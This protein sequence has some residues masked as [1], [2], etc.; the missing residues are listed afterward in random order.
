MDNKIIFDTN[1]CTAI[2]EVAFAS[3]PTC[4]AQADI[5]RDFVAASPGAFEQR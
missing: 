3:D 2:T 5:C 1:F 4:T